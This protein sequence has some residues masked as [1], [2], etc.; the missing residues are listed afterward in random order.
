[1]ETFG[2]DEASLPVLPPPKLLTRADP[3]SQNLVLYDA[4]GRPQPTAWAD[5]TFIAAGKV[6][7]TNFK[8][9][10]KAELVAYGDAPVLVQNVIVAEQHIP[11]MLVE[12][13][14]AGGGRYRIQARQFSYAYLGASVSQRSGDNF[15]TFIRDLQRFASGAFR[16][17]GAALLA[18]EPPRTMSYPS[19]HAFEEEI[20]WC[21]WMKGQG[22]CGGQV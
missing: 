18:G 20:T 1:V 11:Y 22:S 10:R 7:L 6:L 19:R 8:R 5:V 9:T 15:L 2:A 14:L 13:F 17:R 12:V 16:N 21:L 3:L 4:L